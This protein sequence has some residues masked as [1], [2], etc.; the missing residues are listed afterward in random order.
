MEQPLSIRMCTACR[1]VRYCRRGS[2]QSFSARQTE[3]NG[4]QGQLISKR[5]V[6]SQYQHYPE[7]GARGSVELAVSHL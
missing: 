7:A 1:Q 5:L 2:G 4:G 3:Q 6:M